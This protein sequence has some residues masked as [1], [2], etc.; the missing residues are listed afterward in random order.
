MAETITLNQGEYF[1]KDETIELILNG[2][3]YTVELDFV[4]MRGSFSLWQAT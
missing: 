4:S 2:T 1:G 3:E